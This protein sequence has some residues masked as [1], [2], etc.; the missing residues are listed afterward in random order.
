MRVR[1]A[2]QG[3]L[4]V[5]VGGCDDLSVRVNR[6]LYNL[7]NSVSLIIFLLV[8]KFECHATLSRLENCNKSVNALNLK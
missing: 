7:I 5:G 3:T 4:L 1:S 6:I 8:F 2:N